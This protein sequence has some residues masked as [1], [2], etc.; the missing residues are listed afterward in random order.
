MRYTLTTLNDFKL[1]HWCERFVIGTL[2][3]HGM[4]NWLGFLGSTNNNGI[5]NLKEAYYGSLR[6]GAK[7]N[8]EVIRTLNQVAWAMIDGGLIMLKSETDPS[9][10][11]N[12]RYIT[13]GRR[14]F[15]QYMQRR[16]D[17]MFHGN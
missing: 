7:P 8:Q 13:M 14:H 12:D 2:I 15:I 16:N 3:S 5:C 4:G 11:T 1:H 6:L 17:R 10:K 9:Y